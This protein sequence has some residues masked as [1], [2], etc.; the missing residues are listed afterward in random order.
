MVPRSSSVSVVHLRERGREGERERGREGERER[1]REGE[2]ERGREGE[3]EGGERE[4]EREGGRERGR[5]GGREGE[6]EGGREGGRE[7]GRERGREEGREG[8]RESGREGERE[9][10]KGVKQKISCSG[11]N[12]PRGS[13]DNWLSL[14]FSDVSSAAL[15]NTPRGTFVIELCSMDSDWGGMMVN[16]YSQA[17]HV[18][19]CIYIDPCK[20]RGGR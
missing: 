16:I 8:G 15:E 2:R 19:K 7:R 14:R 5:E 12:S 13:V 18:L 11:H 17:T 3:R 20:V 1:G 6:R 10:G 9:G 4:G